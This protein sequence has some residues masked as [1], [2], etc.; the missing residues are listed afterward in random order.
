M[1]PISEYRLPLAVG[2][3]EEEKTPPKAGKLYALLCGWYM[4][5]WIV[6]NSHSSMMIF[7]FFVAPHNILNGPQKGIFIPDKTGQGIPY[8]Y[9][10]AMFLY[11]HKFVATF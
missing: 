6:V 4:L 1:K 8:P 3:D 2:S 5:C 9:S 11:L 10:L 7:V